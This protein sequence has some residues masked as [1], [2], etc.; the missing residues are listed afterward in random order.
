MSSG[1]ADKFM[2]FL[3]YKIVEV[4]KEYKKDLPEYVNWFPDKFYLKN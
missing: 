4:I 2:Q 3:C 1:K